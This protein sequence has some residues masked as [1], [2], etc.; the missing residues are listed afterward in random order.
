MVLNN[1]IDHILKD[2]P[3]PDHREDVI[4]ISFLIYSILKKEVWS[5]E[6]RNMINKIAERLDINKKLLAF[7]S[8]K[9]KKISNEVLS[10]PWQSYFSILLYKLFLIEKEENAEAERLLIRT[11]TLFKS[12][13]ISK[14][15]C[16]S[17]DSDLHKLILQ[18]INI[19]LKS[20][21]KS[22]PVSKE[23]L[24][25][26][27]LESQ[28]IRTIPLTVL[29]YEGPIARAYL[30][31]LYSMGVKPEKII[32]LISS[33]DI[34]SK[35]PIANFLPEYI[36]KFYALLV[37]KT[38]IHFW[39]QYITRTYPELRRLLLE[40][41]RS[42][43]NFSESTLYNAN[44]LNSIKLYSDNIDK[45]MINGLGDKKLQE[46][47]IKQPGSA[48]LY[49][50]GGIMPQSLLGIGHHKFIHIHPGFLPEIRGADCFLWSNLV[51]G[52]PSVSCFYMNSEIDMGNIVFSEWLPEIPLDLGT[53]NYD[54]KILYRSIY[55]FVDPWVRCYALR[56]LV[57]L[58]DEYINM[59]VHSQDNNI[60]VTYH[61]MHPE[62][63]KQLFED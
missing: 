58:N 45:L 33:V 43:L 13:E 30:E 9:W 14:D 24:L 26:H 3:K 56:M 2:V 32:H 37:Q 11:N 28:K 60:G 51:K 47:L 63:Q 22:R 52:K 15:V 48:I 1:L 61:F 25:N 23:I 8:P 59:P 38:R 50:G 39:P 4:Y 44:S 42:S 18:D 54:L 41:V 12:L 10:D 21:T 7:Y 16:L 36:R 62:L 49:T 29:F 53:L 27:V 55:A 34:V 17:P 46:Y 19:F 35:K 6:D 40:R 31:T 20:T 5:I 57:S